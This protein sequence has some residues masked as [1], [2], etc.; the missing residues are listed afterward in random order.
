MPV[1]FP[2]RDDTD[3]HLPSF[4]PPTLLVNS[5][6]FCGSSG[7]WSMLC[8]EV[9]QILSFRSS[10][11]QAS[12]ALILGINPGYWIHPPRRDV[13]IIRFPLLAWLHGGR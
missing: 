6:N 10:G 4:F 3:V 7:L 12:D 1:G 5:P 2:L 11:S 13:E 8:S 9:A